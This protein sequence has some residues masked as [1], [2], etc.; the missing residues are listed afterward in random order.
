M[1]EILIMVKLYLLNINI[2]I[3]FLLFFNV[4]IYIY[5]VE[6]ILFIKC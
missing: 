6:N 3:N 1:L 5:D 2:L 4:D